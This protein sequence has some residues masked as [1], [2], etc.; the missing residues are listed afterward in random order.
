M[1]AP[2]RKRERG[3]SGAGAPLLGHVAARWRHHG[4]GDAEPGGRGSEEANA[5][6]GE[7]LASGTAQG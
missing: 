5:V 7:R 1:T 2:V 6:R 4:P 3:D